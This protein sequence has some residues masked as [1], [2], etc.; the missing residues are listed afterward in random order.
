MRVFLTTCTIVHMCIYIYMI[1]VDATRVNTN[2]TA[3]TVTVFSI[4]RAGL[5]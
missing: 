2:K 1:H 3:T 4:N 5:L